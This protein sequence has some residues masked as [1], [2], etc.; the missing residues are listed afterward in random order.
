M[1]KTSYKGKQGNGAM[2]EVGQGIFLNDEKTRACNVRNERLG[3]KTSMISGGRE[4]RITAAMSEEA[5]EGRV[6]LQVERLAPSRSIDTVSLLI[7]GKAE[8]VDIC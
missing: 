4:R 8:C 3:S 6:E 1:V 5:K 2:K 7:G